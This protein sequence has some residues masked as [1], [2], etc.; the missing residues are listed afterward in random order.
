M[1]FWWMAGVDNDETMKVSRSGGADPEGYEPGDLYVTIK[2]LL[3]Y[4]FPHKKCGQC[5]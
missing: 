2:V 4:F 1:G 5:Q 3:K